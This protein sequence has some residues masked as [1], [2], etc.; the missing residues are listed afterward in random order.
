MISRLRLLVLV[1]AF[2]LLGLFV[3][4]P[5]QACAC[6]GFAAADGEKV[7]ATAEYAA[8]T[9][10]GTTER[11][12]L[13]MNTLTTA[14]DAALLIP[15][16]QRATA[17]LAEPT[18][19]TELADLTAPQTVVRWRWWPEL[20][21]GLTAGAPGS[22]AVA[23]V[24]VLETKQLG[25]LE[26]TSLAATD[27]DA[28]TAWLDHNGYVLGDGLAAALPPYV[29][30]GWYFTAIKLTADAADLTG[31][32]Q[33]LDLRF[34]ADELVY[35]MRLSVAAPES[36]FVRTY[37]FA[38][39]RTERTDP[40]AR[41]GNRQLRFAGHVDPAAATTPSLAAILAAHPYLTATDQYFSDPRTQIVSDFTFGPAASD[42]PYRR[43]TY[44]T[45][46]RTILG[47]PAGPVLLVLGVLAI[48]V[49]VAA[50]LL[51]ARRR[52]ATS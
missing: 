29:A 36:Q 15:T 52:K 18:L 2:S 34:A 9:L 39:H 40:T 7:A 49:A 38:D 48:N 23:P 43:T 12:I 47:I 10:D 24:T 46:T 5:A 19:F 1:A 25:D 42:E 6:G 3:A 31:A 50:A 14:K 20:D 16:P 27:A 4:P 22:G 44:E 30:D 45:H 26:V 21:R 28:L 8:L 41:E 51:V 13:S 17:D 11:V 35:P 33:P 32:L 37:V